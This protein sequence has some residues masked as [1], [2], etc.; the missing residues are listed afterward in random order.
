[1]K[2]VLILVLLT[3]LAIA[4]LAPPVGASTAQSGEQSDWYPQD[5]SGSKQVA[6]YYVYSETCAYC[7]KAKPFIE[8]LEQEYDWLQVIRVSAES[9]TEEQVNRV[10]ALADEVGEDIVGVPTYLFCEQ[11]DGGFDSAEEKGAELEA[12]L[13]RC[14]EALSSNADPGTGSGDS[15]DDLSVPVLGDIDA[16]RVSLPIFTIAVAG[17]DAFNP[18]A[19]FVLL[20]LLSLLV[21]ARSRWRM[22]LVGGVFVVMSGVMYF[23]FMAAWLN[24]FLV[25]GQLRWVTAVAGTIALVIALLNMK[26]YFAPG[27]AGSL[28]IPDAA[29]PGLFARMRKLTTGDSMPTVLAGT[30]ALAAV[31]NSYELLC[32]AGFP[33]V[34]TRVL[35]LNDLSTASY[36]SYLVLY[37][38]V[39][40]IPLLVI[41]GVF[42]WTLGSRKLSEREGQFLKLMSGMMMLGLGLLL[43]IRP[44]LLEN[45]F[46][47]VGILG[48]A[49]AVSFAIWFIRRSLEASP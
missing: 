37:N 29:R 19:F 4:V 26:D 12:E 46:A 20:F 15:D 17:L 45:M 16:D 3:A 33:L 44:A 23:A 7:A 38:L 32:T 10:L 6:F 5:G 36:Y 11:M 18:C 24:V 34:F 25:T 48:G 31:A 41:V 40:V 9:A 27:T 30:V 2:R 8:Y 21:H 49:V 47:A 13:V 22:A 43:L 1:M 28:S 39:Y 42:V 35:T 14:F